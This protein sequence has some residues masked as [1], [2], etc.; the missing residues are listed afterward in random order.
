M[1]AFFPDREAVP[2]RTVNTCAVRAA[3]WPS[4]LL[5]LVQ[6]ASLAPVLLLKPAGIHVRHCSSAR[7]LRLPAGGLRAAHQEAGH[8]PADNSQQEPSQPLCTGDI[9]A[10]A[11]GTILLALLSAGMAGS[12]NRSNAFTHQEERSLKGGSHHEYHASPLLSRV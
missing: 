6:V 2:G 10:A 12:L 5:A 1:W 3:C 9:L 8:K 11:Q 4:P 7:R